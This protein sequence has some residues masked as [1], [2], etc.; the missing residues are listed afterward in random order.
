MF[1]P[2]VGR[3]ASDFGAIS[4]I[5]QSLCK[6]NI[7][8]KITLVYEIQHYENNFKRPALLSPTLGL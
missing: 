8:E 1:Q 4:H 6:C 7:G 5:F 3:Y 2:I